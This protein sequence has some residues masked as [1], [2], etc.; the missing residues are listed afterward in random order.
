MLAYRPEIDGLRAVSVA[1]VILFHLGVLFI[2]GGFVG[3]DVFFVISGYLI[4]GILARELGAGRFSLLSFY[5]RRICRIFPALLAM[6][7]VVLAAGPFLLMPG[8]FEATARSAVWAAASASNFFFWFNTGYFDQA[9]DL[10]PL[11]HTWS[12]AV[13]EQFYLVWPLVIWAS[14]RLSGGRRGVVLVVSLALAAASFGMSLY[15]VATDGRQAFYSPWS[16]T[17]ELALGGGLALAPM[18]LLAKAKRYGNWIAGVGL[19]LIV[20]SALML[21]KDMDFPGWRALPAVIGALCVLAPL[22]SGR[23]YSILSTPGAVFIG[24]ISYSLY[25]WHWPII[26]LYRHYNLGM[27]PGA[28]DGAAILAASVTASWLSWRFIE[29]PAR[30]SPFPKFANIGAGLATACAMMLVGAYVV[31][32]GGFPARIPPSTASLMSL[33][34]M[35]KWDCRQERVMPGWPANSYC[36]LGADWETAK[37]KGV[38]TGDSHAE[39]FA[40]LLDVAAKEAG[41]SLAFYKA[42]MPL[43]GTTSIKRV[44]AQMPTYTHYCTEVSQ[45]L[46]N[47]LRGA[48]DISLVVVAAAWSAYPDS[49]YRDDPSERSREKALRLMA[50]GIDELMQTV[51]APNRRALIIGDV[52][53]RLGYDLGCIVTEESMIFRRHCAPDMFKTP[54]AWV[55]KFQEQAG[56]VIESVPA[57][58][59]A[60]SSLMPGQNMCD[61]DGC[62]TTLDGEFLYRDAGHLRRNLPLN[63][64]KKLAEKI[65]LKEA[66]L[67]AA[68]LPLVSKAE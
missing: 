10:M 15:A 45:P 17:W 54:R 8:D 27:P 52:P 48:K 2:P 4:T 29:Q 3:V 22:Q 50:E 12:L 51:A 26:V 63:I 66:L 55:R 65:G 7:A 62:S 16:R 37:I 11:L 13:E 20:V 32:A 31:R 9:S 34:E 39:H 23:V 36:I 18:G 14:F 21:R 67:K 30:H 59:A 1:L 6:L 49:L 68:D 57:R 5:D 38:L 24:R 46:V 47:Y 58:S 25:L 56:S 60:A 43:V 44:L 53:I 64:R 61:S 19:A 28:I 33:D 42:C 35:W 40:P 41:I